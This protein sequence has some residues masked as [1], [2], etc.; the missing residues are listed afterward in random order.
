MAGARFIAELTRQFNA[1]FP[2]AELCVV[3]AFSSQIVDS[4]HLGQLDCGVI[5]SRKY[6]ETVNTRTIADQSLYLIG[7][8]QDA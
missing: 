8:P 3:E 1:C 7:R 2:F 5:F 6:D 4:L